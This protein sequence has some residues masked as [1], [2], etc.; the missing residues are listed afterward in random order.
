MIMK[1]LFPVLL[2]LLLTAASAQAQEIRAGAFPQ[3]SGEEIFKGVCQ[4]CHMPDAK[5]AVGAGHYPALAGDK[6][7]A[8]AGYPVGIVLHGQKAMPWFSDYFTD[9][10]VANVVNYVRTH[11]GNNYT[12]KVTPADVKQQR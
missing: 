3:Q 7:L 11:F 2:P 8:A 10:Q 6:N 9:E 1:K 5:G 12:D 4:G